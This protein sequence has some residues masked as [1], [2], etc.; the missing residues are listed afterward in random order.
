MDGLDGSVFADDD[1][2]RD[3]LHAVCGADG[4]IGVEEDVDIEFGAFEELLDF[5]FGFALVDGVED[6][7]LIL[8]FFGDIGEDGHGSNAWA[9]PCC[10]EIEDDDF[11]LLEF[12]EF[13]GFTIELFECEVGGGPAKLG[14]VGFGGIEEGGDVFGGIGFFELECFGVDF[15]GGF[16]VGEDDGAGHLDGLAGFFGKRFD[17]GEVVLNFHDPG[18]FADCDPEDSSTDGLIDLDAVDAFSTRPTATEV[19]DAVESLDD[20]GVGIEPKDGSGLWYDATCEWTDEDVIQNLIEL[21]GRFVL[22]V[23]IELG[24]EDVE[25]FAIGVDTA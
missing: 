17:A 11:L 15:V 19:F 22:S 3:A 14:V 21:V 1:G 4:S 12:E 20:G 6:D 16:P 24:R 10:P 13:D 23:L 8:E 25:F 9:T 2:L 18:L 7:I 5:G